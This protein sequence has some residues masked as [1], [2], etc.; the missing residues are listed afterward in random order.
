MNQKQCKEIDELL[1]KLKSEDFH[2]K[3]SI[4]GILCDY[5]EDDSIS[6]QYKNIITKDIIKLFD[7]TN[8]YSLQESIFYFLGAAN[9]SG[10]LQNEITNIMMEFMS[11]PVPEFLQYAIDILAYANLTSSER[12]KFT[13]LITECLD[14]EDSDIKETTN[15]ILED[16][17]E[18]GEPLIKK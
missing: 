15:L 12:G 4:I 9:N 3:N 11:E 5:I 17:E 18:G 10:V 6:S 14:S 2:E 8:S 16:Y 13:R 7:P 1:L